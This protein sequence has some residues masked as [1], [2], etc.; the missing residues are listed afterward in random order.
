MQRLG[1]PPLPHGG[2][3]TARKERRNMREI[4]VTIRQRLASLAGGQAYI[5]GDGDSWVVFDLDDEWSSLPVRTARFQTESGY[6]DT[7]FRG[8]RC[9]IPV[10]G[11]ARRLEVGLY[12]GNVRTTTP[13][14]IPLVEGIRS[15][16]GTPEPPAP[17]VFDQLM[18][19]LHDSAIGMETLDDGV[20]LTLRQ[21]GEE[22]TAFLRH[23]EV[24]VGTGDMP[25]GYRVQLDPS[26]TPPILKVR[27]A[28]GRLYPIA[29]IQGQ[30]GDKG[31]RGDP[32]P[33][34][35]QG[36]PGKGGILAINGRTPAEDNTLTLTPEDLGAVNAK[37]P[38]MEKELDMGGK[39]IF[40][41]AEPVEQQDAAT[42]S[43]V[44]GKRLCQTA[45]LGTGWTGSGPY[46]QTLA[47]VGIRE[48]DCPHITPVY[49][50]SPTAA[51]AQQTAWRCV[52]QAS[53]KDA[54]ICF[55]CLETKPTQAIPIQIEV[56]R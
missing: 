36:A 6:T 41:L 11:Y 44:D 24:Y 43:Y 39:R 35:P 34:G 55:T 5:C 30:K 54:A 50:D 45:L 12:A 18:E 4:F 49:S 3:P 23:S 33:V 53:A 46:S 25:E 42:K 52:S 31:D 32:G 37:K 51:L 28:Q 29:A 9:P 13:A 56:M 38:A 17:T 7:V 27:D 14:P 8:N 20:R 10:I 47:L 40:R 48:S 19:L 16:W 21:R 2:L 15:A 22:H 1:S 26:G